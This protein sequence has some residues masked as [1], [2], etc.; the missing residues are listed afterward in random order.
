MHIFQNIESH[1]GYFSSNSLKT[2]WLWW[3]KPDVPALG[4]LRQDVNLKAIVGCGKYLVRLC[5]KNQTEAATT[6]ESS[7]RPFYKFC[8]SVSLNTKSRPMSLNLTD[9]EGR[10]GSRSSAM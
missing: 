7:M 10:L 3:Q 2:D 1:H 6:E 4:N 5:L 8:F 9:Y